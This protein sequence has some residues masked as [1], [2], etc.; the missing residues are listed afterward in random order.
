MTGDFYDDQRLDSTARSVISAVEH[1]LRRLV[2][3]QQINPD[4]IG[5]LFLL[6][7]ETLRRVGPSASSSDCAH[8]LA[9]TVYLS[10][11]MREPDSG[12]APDVLATLRSTIHRALES[13]TSSRG[14]H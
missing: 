14:L 11:V 5:E 6:T 10:A 1:D 8:E 9:L 3:D 4:L 7:R 2:G 13:A 12:V